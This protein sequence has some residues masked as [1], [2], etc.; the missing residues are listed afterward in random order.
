[1]LRK[2]RKDVLMEGQRR[3]PREGG[4]RTSHCGVNGEVGEGED[5]LKKETGQTGKR[6]EREKNADMVSSSKLLLS[7]PGR[8]EK[9]MAVGWSG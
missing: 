2:E 4:T 5:G 1:M 8:K 6:R 3:C 9:E 7:S